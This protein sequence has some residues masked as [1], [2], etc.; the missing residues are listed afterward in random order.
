MKGIRRL[1]RPRGRY[2][3]HEVS[4]KSSKIDTLTPSLPNSSVA[5]FGCGVGSISRAVPVSV[6]CVYVPISV[7]L[8][9]RGEGFVILLLG[10]CILELVEICGK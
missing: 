6:E 7:A 2:G 1:A 5:V 3:C 9:P 4:E 8:C 10:T